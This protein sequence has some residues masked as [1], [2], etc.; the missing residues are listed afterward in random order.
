MSQ[1]GWITWTG[2]DAVSVVTQHIYKECCRGIINII[3]IIID[4]KKVMYSV[5]VYLQK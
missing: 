3:I 4:T 5:C 2:D 1:A